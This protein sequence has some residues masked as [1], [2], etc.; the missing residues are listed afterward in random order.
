MPDSLQL[1]SLLLRAESLL[2]RFEASLPPPLPQTD[3]VAHIA[4]RWRRTRHAGYLQ[5]ILHPH[6]I[7]LADLDCIDA[8]KARVVANTRQFL[9]G[10][11]AN[12]VLLT[13]TRGSGKSSLVKAL[14]HEFWQTGLRLIE[15]DKEDLVDLPDI[16]D[17]LS[18][19]P[20]RFIIFCD[21]LS[22]AA[23][24]STYKALK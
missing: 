13:G 16:V 11:P 8:Q 22:Y 17:L 20:E 24:E 21:D 2:A 5:P 4:W 23:E 6:R 12:N 9:S 15:V 1:D 3:W 18:G 19:R 10:S 14:L 7:R